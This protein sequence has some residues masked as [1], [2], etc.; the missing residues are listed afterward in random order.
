MKIE[1]MMRERSEAQDDAGRRSLFDFA[2]RSRPCGVRM[3]F[4]GMKSKQF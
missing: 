2:R 3:L 4:L 1:G